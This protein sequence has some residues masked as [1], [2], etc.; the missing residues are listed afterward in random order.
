MFQKIHHHLE[1]I[2]ANTRRQQLN[3]EQA[4]HWA[5]KLSTQLDVLNTS[6]RSLDTHRSRRIVQGTGFVLAGMGLIMIGILSTYTY[7][8]ST[9]ADLARDRSVASLAA[10][11]IVNNRFHEVNDKAIDLE[12]RTTRLD[13]LVQQ[14]ARTILELKKLN[15]TAIRTIYYLHRELYQQ[16]QL[17]RSQ[18]AIAK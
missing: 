15:A 11:G 16:N 7:R 2:N 10:Y 6:V 5:E 18:T 8:L 3:S 9:A 4:D 14:Q 12:A 13:S 17:Q 1:Q